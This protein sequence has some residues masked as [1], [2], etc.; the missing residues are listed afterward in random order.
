MPPSNFSP[1]LADCRPW[2]DLPTAK[3]L[4]AAH[5]SCMKLASRL[6]R[7]RLRLRQP[8]VLGGQARYS[9]TAASGDSPKSASSSADAPPLPAEE[10][11][12]MERADR[13]TKVGAVANH[14]PYCRTLGLHYCNPNTQPG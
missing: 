5:R 1:S 14:I 8:I 10:A 13:I 3:F 12:G 2:S 4:R 7:H 6:S 11:S 9:S